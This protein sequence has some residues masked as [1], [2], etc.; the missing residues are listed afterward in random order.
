MTPGRHRSGHVLPLITITA[1]G[2]A[3][4]LIDATLGWEPL[5]LELLQRLAP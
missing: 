2:L 3:S 4:A 5:A 1:A